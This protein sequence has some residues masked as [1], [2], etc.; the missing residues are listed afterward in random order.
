MAAAGVGPAAADRPPAFAAGAAAGTT[1]EFDGRP[2]L[3]VRS[4]PPGMTVQERAAL[5]AD[6][7]S[8]VAH[9][10]GIKIEDIQPR[11][12]EAAVEIVAGGIMLMRVTDADAAVA[13]R[14]RSALAAE[15]AAQMRDAVN[16]FREARS[17]R[18]R[19][20]DDIEAVIATAAF[21]G[22]LLALRWLRRRATAAIDRRRTSGH[23]GIHVQSVEVV[24]ADRLARMLVEAIAVA[25][26]ALVLILLYGFVHEFLRF[27]PGTERLRLTLRGFV[28]TPLAAIWSG[29]VGSLPSLF[30]VA[31]IALLAYMAIRLSDFVFARIEDRTILLQGFSPDLARPTAKLV[32]L[33]LIIMALVAAFPYLPGSRSPAFQGVSI[34]LGVLLSLG[35]SSAVANVISGVILIYMQPFRPGDRV[36][37]AGTVGDVVEKT[38]LVTR[39]RTVK[40]VIVTIPNATV[41]GFHILN[42]STSTKDVGL[43]LHT[44]VTIGYDDAWRRVHELLIAAARSTSGILADPAPFVLQTAL[45][46]FYVSYEI[47]AYTADAHRM[48]AIY[49]ELH[50]NIQDKFNEAG[51]EINSPHYQ[52]IRDGNRTTIPASYLPTGYRP[53]AFRFTPDG[54]PVQSEDIAPHQAKR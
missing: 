6:R 26:W 5:I 28:T 34:F 32:R 50:A 2:V 14:D 39:I 51:V 1:V 49:S 17:L 16:R 11:S 23:L 4:A 9:T 44:T 20:L 31:I 33:L 29:F 46:D 40:N 41:M 22:L 12:T 53:P 36:S 38:L 25:Y 45:N 35:S 42:Y 3:V 47:N 54:E 48:A 7:L 52:A 43:I 15:Y 30:F 10:P 13:G 8:A 21:L 37:I 27:F 18:S 24:R 19:A